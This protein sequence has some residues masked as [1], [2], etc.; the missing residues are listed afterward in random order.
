M[1]LWLINDQTCHSFPPKWTSSWATLKT[2]K[3]EFFYI[4][5]AYLF[6]FTL[7][8]EFILLCAQNSLLDSGKFLLMSIKGVDPIEVKYFYEVIRWQVNSFQ[9]IAG[10]SLLF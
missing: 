4:L 2:K 9:M 1:A 10:S 6:N 7:I 8:M 3:W 5:R